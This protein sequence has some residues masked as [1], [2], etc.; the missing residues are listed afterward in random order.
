V[1][2]KSQVEW[3]V[4]SETFTA[5]SQRLPTFVRRTAAVGRCRHSTGGSDR[6]LL[7][8]PGRTR[9]SATRPAATDGRF[10]ARR[11]A[12]RGPAVD[13]SAPFARPNSAPYCCFLGHC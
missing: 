4:V 5:R 9:T 1:N 7:A 3:S 2:V 11:S 6:Q 8:R 12:A 13:P 10:Q